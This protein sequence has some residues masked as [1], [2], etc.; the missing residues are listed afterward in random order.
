VRNDHPRPRGSELGKPFK[1]VAL[2]RVCTESSKRPNVGADGDL[3]AVDR[4]RAR[5]LDQPPAQRPLPL[6]SNYE[7]MRVLV[8]QP[9]TE[10]MENAPSIAH[11][12][13]VRFR[14]RLL[15][16]IKGLRVLRRD[17]RMKPG[18]VERQKSATLAFEQFFVEQFWMLDHGL[19]GLIAMGMST[20]T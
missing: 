3:F 11:A 6:I 1:Q 2:T 7:H 17:A 16:I 5:T 4:D 20:H 12:G 19:A 9:S 8:R 18:F 14:S 15:D 13:A 10:V